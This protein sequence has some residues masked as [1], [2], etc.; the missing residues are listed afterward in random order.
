MIPPSKTLLSAIPLR[1]L[2]N[3]VWRSY[4]GGVQLDRLE[5]KACPQDSHFPEDWIGSSVKAINPRE[6]SREDEGL[7]R[8]E[9]N[10]EL[11]TLASLYRSEP[12]FFFGQ[13][14]AERFG[15]SPEFLVK[16][17]DSADRLHFQCHPTKAF[18]REHLQS[19]YG[20]F[21]AYYVLGIR[22]DAEYGEV[23]V[24]FQR[25]PS[26]AMLRE[27]IEQ[28]DMDAIAACFDPLPVKAGDVVIVP[29][30]TP[31][32]LGGG[33]LL[34]EILEPSDWVV[35][36]EYSRGGYVLP[37]ADRFMGRDLDFALDVFD[38]QPRSV[39]D[40]RRENICQPQVM[41]AVGEV[42]RERLI[43]PEHTD[44]FQV[45]RT[46]WRGA[47]RREVHAFCI[48]IV[49]SGSCRLG[50]PDGWTSTLNPFDRVVVPHA[51]HELK[52]ESSSDCVMLECYPPAS[53]PEH[54]AIFHET[55]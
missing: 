40:V 42:K 28:Q 2:P 8:V 4:T 17:I 53:N 31:H 52:M 7:A 48:V 44:C 11:S 20:K 32:A 23:Y 6:F 12:D 46:S 37:E 10:G 15:H 50:G 19:S 5:G 54:E 45:W 3:R 47:A 13:G 22:D 27:Y 14:H 43:G 33:V 21:E 16:F 24:G 29:G 9:L 39:D 38:L 34:V 36:F 55:Y 18:S 26:R 49:L 41:S 35:R 25:A 51:L 30:G 1:L